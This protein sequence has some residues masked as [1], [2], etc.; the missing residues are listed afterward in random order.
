MREV[1]GQPAEKIKDDELPAANFVLHSR[2]E[3]EQINHVPQ[4]MKQAS[5]NKKGGK[6]S[7]PARL[8]RN[9]PKIFHDPKRRLAPTGQQ[10]DDADQKYGRIDPD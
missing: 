2:A 6:V 9:Q 3:Q 7:R 5:M 10:R 4:K 8:R 1:G